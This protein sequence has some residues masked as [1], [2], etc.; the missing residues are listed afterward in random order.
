MKLVKPLTD[1]TSKQLPQQTRD[2]V[3][4]FQ[5]YQQQLQAIMLQKE[6]LRLQQIEVENA[7]E[8]LEIGKEKEGY[9]IV[10]SIMIKKSVKD[11]KKELKEKN[12]NINLRL[13][14]IERTENKLTE[15]LRELQGKLQEMLRVTE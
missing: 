10:G 4:Q 3:K 9:K 1:N 8:E 5:N 13:K 11:L 12:D 7:L 14:T 2:L 15:R 6:S